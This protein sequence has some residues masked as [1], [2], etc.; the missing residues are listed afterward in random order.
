MRFATLFCAFALS[1]L[2]SYAEARS[3]G[4]VKAEVVT[5]APTL[6]TFLTQAPGDAER[7]FFTERHGQIRILMDGEVLPTPF[8]DLTSVVNSS[9]GEGTLGSLA[10]HPDYQSNG[11]FY[12]VYTNLDGDSVLAELTVTADPSVADFAS[13]R[14][15]LTITEP[16]PVHNIGWIGFG[17]DGFLYMAKGDGGFPTSG[18]LAQD[19]ESL[20]GKILRIDPCN[21]DFPDDPECHYAIPPSNPFVGTAGRDEIWALGLRNP[22]RCSF[23]RLTGDLW[24]ADVGWESWEEINFQPSGSAGGENYGWNCK[25]AL[26]CC[27]VAVSA[28][29][30][31]DPALIDPV[32][33]YDHDTGCAVVGGYVYRGSALPRLQGM[34]LFADLCS[35]MVWAYDIS[36]DTVVHVV[37]LD[38]M[39]LSFGEDREGELYVLTTHDIRKLVFFD[40]NGNGVPDEQDIADLT[41]LDC[42]LDTIPDECQT[43]DCNQNSIPDDCDI[44]AGT[45][46]DDDGN[47]VPDEC[48]VQADIDGNG[49]VGVSDLLILL[50]GWGPCPAPPAGCPA[51]LNG[52]GIVGVND[53]LR[54]L[55]SWG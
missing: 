36:N 20:F 10:F 40:C 27:P 54:V 30:C 11:L 23:D 44:A 50:L 25:E 18:E 16:G 9:V 43:N 34:Y 19:I 3:E 41:S 4:S 26:S 7:F 53:L 12:V 47:G 42:N 49:M 55:G 17:P 29:A 37:D 28:C 14:V 21:D 39:P 8:V 31:R 5:T 32:Y 33:D 48:D 24:I 52:D 46:A 6:P 51:D 1:V 22:W 15:L 45:S 2:L 35:K 38:R 13:L